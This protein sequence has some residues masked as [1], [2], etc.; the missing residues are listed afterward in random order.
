MSEAIQDGENE[1]WKT[2]KFT[3]S[4]KNMAVGVT[5]AASGGIAFMM[6]LTDVFFTQAMAWVFVIW[7]LL[8]IYIGLLD[9]AETFEVT[10][11]ALII[12]N[13]LRPFNSKKVWPWKDVKRMDVIVKHRDARDEDA[14]LRVYYLDPDDPAIGRGDRDYAPTLAR[15]IIEKAGLSPADESNPSDLEH[16]PPNQKATYIWKK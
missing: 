13:P 6:G 4:Q 15:L 16:L 7:G 14:M 2:V 9:G 8:F 10:D 3:G 12:K 11:D 5:L 1:A